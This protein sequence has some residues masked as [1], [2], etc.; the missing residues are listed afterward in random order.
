MYTSQGS[1]QHPQRRSSSPVQS[2]A[3]SFGN[4]SNACDARWVLCG[5]HAD[6]RDISGY[7][8]TAAVGSRLRCSDAVALGWGFPKFRR[9]LQPSGSRACLTLDDAQ[10]PFGTSEPLTQRHGPMPSKTQI[11]RKSLVDTGYNHVASD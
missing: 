3:V 8:S 2:M 11:L 5:T 10:H 6:S 7:H 9:T 4:A 1:E